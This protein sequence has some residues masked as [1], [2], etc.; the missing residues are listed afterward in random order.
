MIIL[1]TCA[2]AGL[3]IVAVASSQG[4]IRRGLLAAFVSIVAL[5]LFAVHPRGSLRVLAVTDAVLLAAYVGTAILI[6][7]ITGRLR[8]QRDALRADADRAAQLAH[9]LERELSQRESE[10]SALH[11]LHAADLARKSQNN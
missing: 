5:D 2:F 9:F 6:S 11:T 3:V 8:T 10:V 7:Y 4:G 1:I